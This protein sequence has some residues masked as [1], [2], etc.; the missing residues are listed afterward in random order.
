VDAH[1]AGAV[2]AT[3]TIR[4]TSRRRIPKP[5]V[6]II[7]TIS[8][9]DMLG[10]P[11]PFKM[12]TD[13]ARSAGP[14]TRKLQVKLHIPT[15]VGKDLQVDDVFISNYADFRDQHEFPIAADELYDWE[16]LAGPSGD[17]PVYIRFAASP[18]APVGQATIVLDQELPK[19]KPRFMG[20]GPRAPRGLMSVTNARPAYCG[21]APRRWLRIPGADGFSGLNAVQIATNV[22]HPCGWRPYL[23]TLSYRAP[24]KVIFLRIEDRVGNI[25]RWYRVRTT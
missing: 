1:A 6:L 9:T 20:T 4:W 23:P 25:S 10:R 5:Q 22:N 13:V 15:P 8:A 21:A 17:R 2:V 24:G 19:L 11:R 3:A 16:L 7:P 18:E 14:F 12:S